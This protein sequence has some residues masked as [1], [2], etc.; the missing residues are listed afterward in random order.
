MYEDLVAEIE[1]WA[2][3]LVEDSE[4]NFRLM[5]LAVDEQKA[6]IHEQTCAIRAIQLQMLDS[7]VNCVRNLGA[8]G[9]APLDSLTWSKDMI[10]QA[11]VKVM[12]SF[13]YCHFEVALSSDTLMTLQEIDMMRKQAARLV[14]KAVSQY[15]TMKRWAE[16]EWLRT[17]RREELERQAKIIRETPEVEWSEEQKAVIKALDDTNWNRRY[18][19]EDDWPGKENDE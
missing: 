11:S 13:D 1:R 8:Q 6:S 10:A 14:D 7:V 4:R 18:D 9:P 16:N 3:L 19:Y 12:R 17:N 2:Q 5:D 15:A